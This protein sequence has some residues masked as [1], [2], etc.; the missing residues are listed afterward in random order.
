MRDARQQSRRLTR[1]V[2]AQRAAQAEAEAQADTGHWAAPLGSAVQEAV[3]KAAKVERA[4]IPQA[5][6]RRQQAVYDQLS[7]TTERL[8]LP[9]SRLL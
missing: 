8:P 3:V 9:L 1:G 6:S 5:E 2:E 4:A 7:C